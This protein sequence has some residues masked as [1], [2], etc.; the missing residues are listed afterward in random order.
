MILKRIIK[1]AKNYISS[2]YSVNRLYQLCV[3]AELDRI[4]QN[5][6][7]DDLKSLIR[8]G[9][10]VYSQND[11][12]GIIREIFSRI[13]TSNKTFVEFGVGDGMENNTVA[14]LFENWKGLWIDYSKQSIK[15]INCNLKNII[16]NG[17]LKIIE[18][19]IT[20]DNI[21]QL[22]SDNID[23]REIDLLSIDIDG[24][25]YHV[26]NAITCINPRGAWF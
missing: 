12:D 24:N 17:Q 10:K 5:P 26:L 19:M 15:T 20:K 14:L 25:D 21:N 16:E 11:E 6:R 7:Y 13:G 8:F 18:A 3:H 4:K 22:I 1:L 23:Y 9:S 2:F